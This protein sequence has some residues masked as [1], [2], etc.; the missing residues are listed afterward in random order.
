MNKIKLLSLK[1]SHIVAL[2]CLVVFGSFQSCGQDFAQ[3][4]GPERNGIYNEYNLL[5]EWPENG[6][7]LLWSY[8]GIGKGYAAPVVLNNMV[9]VN[10]ENDGNSFLFA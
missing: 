9:F 7:D 3:W 4:H 6:P 10:G 1:R 5:N 8:D 2:V